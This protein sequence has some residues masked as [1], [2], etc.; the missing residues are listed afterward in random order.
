MIRFKKFGENNYANLISWIDSEEALMQFAGRQFTFPLTQEQLDVSLSDKNRIALSIE[1][2]EV[3]SSI[4]HA[5][6]YVSEN[7]AKI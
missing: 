4:G 5:E 6:I 1:S 2:E 7:S 3:N